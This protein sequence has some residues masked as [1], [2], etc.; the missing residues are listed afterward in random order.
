[1]GDGACKLNALTFC[2]LLDS[3]SAGATGFGVS[4]DYKNC[5]LALPASEFKN[6]AGR[7]A[8]GLAKNIDIAARHVGAILKS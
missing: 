5:S 7:V 2:S 8:V 6:P 3:P 4:I 1:M